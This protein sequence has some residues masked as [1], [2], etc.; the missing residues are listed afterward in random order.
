MR[1]VKEGIPMNA[2][3]G[4]PRVEAALRNEV[5]DRAPIALWR[6]FPE[7]DQ[8]VE[9]LVAHTLAWQDRWQFDLVK[10]MPSGTYGVEDWGAVSA[11][12]GAANGARQ[13]V[14]PAVVYT[15][16][17]RRIGDLDVRKGSYGRQNDALRA[18]AKSL[19]GRVPL[20][21]TVFSPLT[22]ARKLSTDRLFADMRTA[23]DALEEA[24][25]AITQVTIRFALDAIDAGAHG[26]FFATQLASFR[27][28]NS[29]EYERF[30]Q[31]YDLDV[32][33]AL[34]GRSRLDM[35]HAHGEDIMFDLLSTY[36]VRMLNWHDRLAGPEL[37]HAAKQFP[38]LLVG[39]LAENDAL[40]RGDVP[41]IEDEVRDALAQTG[42][43]RLMVGPGC[44]VPIAVGDVAID[45]VIR[46]T[47]AYGSQPDPGH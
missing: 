11:F 41:A 1:S 36:P 42:G 40:L 7:D 9:K 2:T 14:K 44:V 33:A 12:R 13:I 28:M 32:L 3:T 15:D 19:A 31:A 34:S 18:A 45:T 39:G 47:C 20:L 30:G 24:L 25:R 23:P 16:D 38:G 22:T 43:R 6:H 26:I 21:Q 17:W 27:M 37:R 10:F 5:T 35:L 4:W 8:H 46:A 29:K